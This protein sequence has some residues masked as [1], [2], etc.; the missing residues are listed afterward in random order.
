[1]FLVFNPSVYSQKSTKKSEKKSTKEKVSEADKLKNEVIIT[2]GNEKITFA[3]LE[4]AFRKNMN[5]KDVKL[6]EVSRDSLDDFIELYTKYRLKVQDA[7]QRGFENDSSVIADISQN[8]RILAES[9]F[10]DKKLVDKMVD[11]MLRKRDRE[12]QI[13]IMLFQFPMGNENDSMAAYLKGKACLDLLKQGKDFA[14]LAKDSSDDKESGERGGVISTWIT[15]GRTQRPIEDAIYKTKPGNYYPDLI[16]T[17]YG[18]F[19]VKVLKSEPRIKVRGSHILLSE[20][21]DKDSARVSAKADSILNLI[22]KGADFARLAE[23]NSED[24]SSAIKGGD[25][26]AWYSRSSG[27][28]NTGRNLLPPF[29]EAL[30]SLKDGEISGKVFTD[31]GIHIIKRDSSKAFKLESEREEMKKL[32]KRIY[33]E[34]DKRDFLDSVK[35]SFGFNIY[36]DVLKELVSSI[37]S[38]KNNLDT[39]WSKD[40]SPELRNKNLYTFNNNN[41]KVDYVINRM[42]KQNDLRGFGL[43]T[44]DFKVAIDKLT[45]PLVYDAISPQLEKEYPD[46]ANLLKEFK[47]GILLFKVEAMEVWDKLKFDSVLARSY[48]DTTKHK[49]ITQPIYDISEIYVLSDSLANDIYNRLKAGSDFAEL[50]KQHTQRAGYREKNGH[51]GRV[52]AKDNQL[53]KIVIEDNLKPGEFSKPHRYDNG[54]SIVKLNDYEAPRQK[55]FEEA[56]PDFAPTFQDLLQKHLSEKWISSLK[57]KYN[58]KVDKDKLTKIMN[59]LK[60]VS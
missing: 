5:R 17:R 60:K 11:D 43:N 7:I 3:D 33:F 24:P 20:G 38:T 4:K 55:T 31:Y 57:A 41:Y 51:W 50:A 29:E 59:S 47:D 44:N 6:W 52:T 28:E 54:F 39:T 10:L 49:Y 42:N 34:S 35:K 25:L 56:I 40:I 15:A 2:V 18:Y 9:Y 48:W 46:Y 22:R 23:E 45:D 36:Y 37:D 26:G 21:L 8:R 30:F 13:A 32:Y 1:M 16:K 27:M 19:I 58:V 12:L 14:E 53:A